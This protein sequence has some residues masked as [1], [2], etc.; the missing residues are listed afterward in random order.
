M[1]NEAC[2]RHVIEIP[3]V[4]NMSNTIFFI[5][6]ICIFLVEGNIFDSKHSKSSRWLCKCHLLSVE[7]KIFQESVEGPGHCNAK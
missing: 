2:L 5:F 6:E 1:E 4:E 7:K 3:D